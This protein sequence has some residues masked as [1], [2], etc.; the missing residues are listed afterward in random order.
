MYANDK[1]GKVEREPMAQ[2]ALITGASGGIG[3]ELAQ[4]FAREKH[5]LVLV[6]RSAD[7]LAALA[8]QLSQ[9]YGITATVIALDLGKPTAPDELYAEL[10]KRGIPIDILV[11]NAGYAGYGA[12]TA[13]DI[14]MELGMMQ[15]NMVTL[16][17]LTKLFL[18][19][20][21]QRGAGRVLNIASTAAFQPGP[22]MAVSYATKA[23]VLSFSEALAEE[24]HGS[25]VTVTALCPGPTQTGFQERAAMQDSKLVAGGGL[26]TA[27]QVAEIGYRATMQGTRVAVPGLLNQILAFTHRFTPRSWATRIVLNMQQRVGH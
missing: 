14:Q 23:Y 8:Q 7:K 1:I 20:M 22:L 21:Q 4:V 27:A 17:H 12:F 15:L 16:T 10:Q 11:N 13:T 19:A 24:L 2:T 6:A 26:M 25:G 9:Q 5:N 3:Y 18:P